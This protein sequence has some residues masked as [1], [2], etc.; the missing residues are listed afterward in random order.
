ML[1]WLVGCTNS[2]QRTEVVDWAGNWI[3]ALLE[4]RGGRSEKGGGELGLREEERLEALAE[5]S[6]QGGAAANPSISQLGLVWC[7][8][9]WRSG[10]G[11]DPSSFVVEQQQVP[12]LCFPLQSSRPRKSAKDRPPGPSRPQY[13]MG[14]VSCSAVI[15]PEGSVP[16]CH[17]LP[18][19][20]PPNPP[21]LK[22]RPP[23]PI[24]VLA[25]ATPYPRASQG[26]QAPL[27]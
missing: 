1:G 12:P 24:T 2:N 7:R 15:A 23:D 13:R 5:S 21:A 18:L 3:M 25:M 16:Y 19:L 11:R 27:L 9:S 26:S 20:K 4:R 10:V 8:P 14:K 22:C 6:G 17:L